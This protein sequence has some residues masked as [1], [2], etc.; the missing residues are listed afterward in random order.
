MATAY[1]CIGSNLGD[2]EANLNQAL[3]LLSQKVNVN[4]ASSIYE[5]EPIGYKEQP[6][7]LNMVCETSTNL[8]PRELLHFAEDIEDKMGRKSGF[9]NS[10]RLIDI[11]ILFYGTEIIKTKDLTI[12]HPRLTERAFVLIPLDEI[13]SELIH[14][15]LGKSIAELT[16]NVEGCSGVHKRIWEV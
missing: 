2:R 12:P 6:M 16:E 4:K 3:A 13:A 10:P 9:R 15:E 5:T 1:L 11:D 14:P 7:F 8:E